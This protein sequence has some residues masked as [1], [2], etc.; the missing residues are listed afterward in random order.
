MDPL[1]RALRAPRPCTATDSAV[2]VE[3]EAGLIARAIVGGDDEVP[4]AGP[5]QASVSGADFDGSAVVSDQPEADL[6][7]G[8]IGHPAAV[9]VARV[10]LAGERVVLF[11]LGIAGNGC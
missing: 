2:Q 4:T 8:D 10:L 3:H 5:Q 7:G 6:P 11:L 1:S 9:P